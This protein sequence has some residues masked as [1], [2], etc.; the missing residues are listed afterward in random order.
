MPLFALEQIV[1][2]SFAGRDRVAGARLRARARYEDSTGGREDDEKS[3]AGSP[4]LFP[5]L[6]CLPS[7]EAPGCTRIPALITATDVYI[8]RRR[9]Q[10][11]TL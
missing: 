1:L 2:L 5:S 8:A 9:D 11:L 7:L 4:V 3:S 6:F 10:Q